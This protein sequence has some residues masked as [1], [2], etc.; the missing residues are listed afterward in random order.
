MDAVIES[1]SPSLVM[2]AETAPELDTEMLQQLQQW[3]MNRKTLEAERD[4]LRTY[5]AT[6]GFG[7]DQRRLHTLE[8]FLEK[9]SQR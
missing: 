1:V 6:F 4:F 7:R 5:A 9:D 3:P 8:S 2:D